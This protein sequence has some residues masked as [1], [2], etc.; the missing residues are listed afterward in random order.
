M[1]DADSTT[2][3][4][5]FK[6][7]PLTQGQ[8]AIVDPEDFDE[9]SKFRWHITKGHTTFYARRNIYFNGKYSVISMHRLILGLTDPRIQVDH[10]NRNGIDNRRFNLR[11]CD[12][13]E[14]QGNSKSR[15]GASQFKGVSWHKQ[16]CRWQAAI[17]AHHKR[18]YL[19]LFDNE[20]DAAKAYNAASVR[21]FGEFACI[22]HDVWML[23]PDAFTEVVGVAAKVD[24]VKEAKP[25]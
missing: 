12:Q 10:R 2:I 14:N 7:I 6:L 18:H 16:R 13:C 23:I 8:F 15:H 1:S 19:G 4:E 24:L 17:T 25:V 21:Y 20:L 5:S 22:N 9:L 11:S 3:V